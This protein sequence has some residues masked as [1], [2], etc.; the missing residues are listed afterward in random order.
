MEQMKQYT[1]DL[2]TELVTEYVRQEWVLDF[3]TWFVNSKWYYVELRSKDIWDIDYSIQESMIPVEL[4]YDEI[5]WWDITFQFEEDVS[6][7]D[8][9]EQE[10]CLEDYESLIKDKDKYIKDKV[11]YI[12]SLTC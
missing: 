6:Y 3:Y 4:G 2:L 1:I 7:R 5:D 10:D 8:D 11:E 12:I 9:D